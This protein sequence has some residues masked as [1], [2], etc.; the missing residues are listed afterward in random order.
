[1]RQML[2]TRVI[3]TLEDHAPGLSSIVGHHHP[4]RDARDY[5][6]SGGDIFHGELAVGSAP[7]CDR[8][9]E[10]VGM[11]PR[12]V[13]YFSAERVRTRAV[14]SGINGRLAAQHLLRS[15]AVR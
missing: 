7:P 13:A 11:K 1:M 12:F 4:G 6:F 15:G 3:K 14:L 2:L 9:L 10:W 8:C 5:G